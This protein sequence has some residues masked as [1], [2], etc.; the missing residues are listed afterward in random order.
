MFGIQIFCETIIALVMLRLDIRHIK[1]NIEGRLGRQLDFW[2][3]THSNRRI[4]IDLDA[5]GYT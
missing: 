4:K 3:Y 2:K 1:T 5:E